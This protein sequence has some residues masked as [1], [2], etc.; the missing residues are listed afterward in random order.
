MRKVFQSIDKDFN[1]VLDKGELIESLVK[2]KHENPEAEADRIFE[3]AD[4]D[5]NGTIEFS[6]WVTATMD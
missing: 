5:K 2:M 3:M 6:E 4:L 1:G